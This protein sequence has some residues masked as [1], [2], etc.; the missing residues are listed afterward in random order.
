MTPLEITKEEDGEILE[1]PLTSKVVKQNNIADLLDPKD[2]I[3]ELTIG[4]SFGCP[5]PEIEEGHL[6][7][8]NVLESAS[9]GV[10][11]DADP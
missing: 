4:A 3:A 6:V 1:F 8:F 2:G 11:I 7:P 10:F 9:Q 5:A